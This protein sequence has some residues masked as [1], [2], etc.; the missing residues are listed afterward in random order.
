MTKNKYVGL[1]AHTATAVMEVLNQKG[2][3]ENQSVVEMREEALKDFFRG[4]SGTV[5][6]TFE[7]GVHARWLYELLKPLVAEVTV[8]DPRHNRLLHSGNKSD[9]IDAH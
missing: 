9:K 7:E 5:H 3:T 2:R 6:V 1:D 4:L 8:C